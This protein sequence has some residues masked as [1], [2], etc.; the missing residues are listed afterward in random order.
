MRRTALVTGSTGQL[1]RS[2][3][4]LAEQHADVEFTFVDRALLDLA[5]PEQV[6]DYLQKHQYDYIVNCGAYTA[7]DKAE[8]ERELAE[9]VNHHAVA[10]L[11][12]AAKAQGAYLIHVSTDYVFDGCH[13]K[14]YAEDH[15]TAPVNNYGQ[16]K[17]SGE[18]AIQASGANACI[19]RTSWVYSQHG[20]N[21]VKTMLR[22]GRE[23]DALTVID[24]QVGSPT[25]AADLASAIMALVQQQESNPAEGCSVFHY[26]NEGVCSWYDFAKAIFELSGVEC[27]VKP[28]ETK[29]YP[30]PAARPHYSLL[31]KQKFKQTTGEI[32]PYWRDALVV[33]LDKIKADSHV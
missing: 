6:M 30:T 10:A 1:G 2:L 11:A 28:I 26:S 32:V 31:S 15:P 29:D 12:K 24:D 19:V 8:Q 25:Y 20:N 17:L 3:Q 9:Q 5:A 21:F 4:D 16:T 33:C 18:L 14:P 23:R 13:Y 22:L 27:K 7:V